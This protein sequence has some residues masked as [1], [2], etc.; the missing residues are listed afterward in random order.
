MN[1]TNIS[2]NGLDFQPFTM[3]DID[4]L[5]PIMKRAFDVD[6][7]IH[8]G[9][10]E[11][12]PEGYHN[13]DLFRKW[14]FHKGVTPFKISKDGRPIGAIALWINENNV[15]YLG[16]I[17]IDPELQDKG[18]GKIVWYST[19]NHYYY[20]NK[21]G[22]KITGIQN[23]KNTFDPIDAGSNNINEICIYLMEK[24]MNVK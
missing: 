15:N 11:G 9:K 22:F 21:C 12:G 4:V 18:M 16:N 7:K 20:V 6:T 8:T 1:T 14:Y 19:R 24:E 2:F 23:P 3:Q 17:F 5:T 13:G 10:E